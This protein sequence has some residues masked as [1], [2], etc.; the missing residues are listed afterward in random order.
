[1]SGGVRCGVEVVTVQPIGED[2]LVQVT[3]GA[4]VPC[5]PASILLFFHMPCLPYV[6]CV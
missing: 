2:G 6:Q 5:S 3:R 1:M 4:S